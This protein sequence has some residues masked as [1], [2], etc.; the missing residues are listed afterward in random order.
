MGVHRA[1]AQQQQDDIP[2]EDWQA[3]LASLQDR[4]GSLE[5]GHRSHRLF[6]KWAIVAFML[7]YVLAA[8]GVWNGLVTQRA[9]DVLNG[10]YEA[11]VQQRNQQLQELEAL[12]RETNRQSVCDLLDGL[13][14]GGFLDPKRT[15]YRCG[16]GLPLSEL[17]PEQRQELQSYRQ[18]PLTTNNEPDPLNYYAEPDPRYAEPEASADAAVPSQAPAAAPASP[19][20]SPSPSAPPLVDLGPITDP[21]CDALGI[22]A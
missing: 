3:E 1:R 6:A 7:L 10:D 16:P 15:E 19:T 18:G 21:V 5:G 22:C 8:G 12:I 9:L 17:S 20:P 14:A 4:V 13:P 2:P 11:R